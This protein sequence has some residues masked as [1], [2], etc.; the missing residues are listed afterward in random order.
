MDVLRVGAD[1]DGGEGGGVLLHGDICNVGDLLGQ[2]A[3]LPGAGLG[4]EGDL[5]GG[6]QLLFQTL[7][8]AEGHQFPVGDDED[9]V[10]DGLNLRENVGAED[11]GVGLAQLSD[12]VPDLDDLQ[13]VQAHGGLI[14][15]DD[16]GA[17]QQGLGD[18]HPLA[19]AL[20][21]GGDA[22]VL[23]VLEPGLGDNLLDLEIQVRAPE[24]FGLSHEPEILQG[25]LVHVEGRLF[26]EVA[27][28]GLGPAGLLKDIVAV[29][30][31]TARR[32]GETAG[33]DVHGGGF[34]RPIGAQKAVHMP[35]L[36]GEGEIVHR[37]EVAV[38]FGQMLNRNHG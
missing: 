12:E 29:D 2:G 37:H 33:H 25:R 5:A 31:H 3:D 8:V 32:G 7:R 38:T 9:L 17:A 34:P 13:G 10:A 24:A 36:D 28:E 15:N 4:G 27:D 23:H 26:R 21:Q 18:A 20:G 14:Q 16:L 19:V 22:A 35:L 11:H 30:A 6:E 1:P